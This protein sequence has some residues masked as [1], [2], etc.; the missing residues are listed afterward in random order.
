MNTG[1]TSLTQR[2][3][4]EMWG[5]KSN[6]ANRTKK[7]IYSSTIDSNRAANNDMHRNGDRRSDHCQVRRPWV[8]KN[9]QKNT[10]VL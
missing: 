1:M 3:H 6:W 4:L 9:T 10:C 8:Q 2:P 7:Y 5:D